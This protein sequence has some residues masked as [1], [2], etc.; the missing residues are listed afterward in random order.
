MGEIVSIDA[1]TRQKRHY[2]PVV[3]LAHAAAEFDEVRLTL[4]IDATSTVHDQ[5]L[6]EIGAAA[7]LGTSVRAPLGEPDLSEHLRARRASHES[8]RVLQRRVDAIPAHELPDDDGRA[9][10]A[11]TRDS[12]TARAELKA[13]S[14]RSVPVFEHRELLLHALRQASERFRLV[15]S[16]VRDA[17]VTEEFVEQVEIM[18]RRPGVTE[19]IGYG[20]TALD[21]DRENMAVTRLKTLASRCPNLPLA[22]A[23]V[24]HPH[25]L[26][27]GDTWINSSFDWLGHLGGDLVFRREEGTLI[28]GDQA[29]IG[30]HLAVA[31]AA[32]LLERDRQT[33]TAKARALYD[34]YGLPALPPGHAYLAWAGSPGRRRSSRPGRHRDEPAAGERVNYGERTP[35]CERAGGARRR[36]ER[37]A[38]L[39]GHPGAVG[40]D[41]QRE[42][43]FARAVSGMEYRAAL[44][45]AE[46]RLASPGETFRSEGT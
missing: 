3:L 30:Q 24:E 13:L 44:L 2:L 14:V 31:R 19:H 32:G 36:R 34:R 41:G 26:I 5:V 11:A 8:V 16:N 42:S 38:H 4:V 7:K 21:R 39:D 20:L 6:T 18:L 37:L 10:S 12:V 9:V 1:V 28:R 35:A 23:E 46:G 43:G 22:H 33:P 27:F 25:A 29:A 40:V 15:T 45:R 17:V